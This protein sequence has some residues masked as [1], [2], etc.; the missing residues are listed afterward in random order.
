MGQYQRSNEVG[1]QF[2]EFH[3]LSS[4][5]VWYLLLS[6]LLFIFV[7]VLYYLHSHMELRL[8]QYLIKGLVLVI[9]S[10]LITMKE[11]TTPL[12]PPPHRHYW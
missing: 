3:L 2:I 9:L 11:K 8:V 5:Y 12:L 4:V 1:K 6:L 7:L 10:L